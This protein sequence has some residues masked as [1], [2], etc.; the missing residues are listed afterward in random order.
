M[1]NETLQ[2]ASVFHSFPDLISL[3]YFSIFHYSTLSAL[4]N[5]DMKEMKAEG[6]EN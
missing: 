1:S 4:K 6:E 2:G 3:W 5:E